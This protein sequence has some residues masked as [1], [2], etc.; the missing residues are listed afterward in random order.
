[1]QCQ[2]VRDSLKDYIEQLDT[3]QFF[4]HITF[5]EQSRQETVYHK[6]WILHGKVVIMCFLCQ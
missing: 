3:L 2:A 4:G 1:M 5:V 6:D